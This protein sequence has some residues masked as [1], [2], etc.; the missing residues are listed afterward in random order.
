MTTPDI[1]LDYAATT[2]LDERVL[3]AMLPHLRQTH[4]NPNS[5]YHRGRIAHQALENAR[6]SVAAL[7]GAAYPSGVT[8][9][10]CGTES[11]N[12]A[13]IGIA[14]AVRRQS[15]R[16]HVVISAFEHHAVLEP[17]EALVKRGFELVTVGPRPD[18]VVHAEDLERVVT[19]RTALVSIMHVNNEIG[20]IMPLAALVEVA[21]TRGALFHSDTIQSVGKID[22]NVARLGLD[23]ASLSAHKIYGPKGVGAL[24]LKRG[25]PFVPY[26]MG[27]GQEFKHRS[28]TQNVAGAAGL[29]AALEIIERERPEESVRLATLRDRMVDAI[30]TGIPDTDLHGS[31]EALVPHIANLSLVG[32]EGESMLLQLDQKGIAVATGSAC[33]SGSLQPSHV[34]LAIGVDPDSAHASLRLSVGRYTTDEDVERFIAELPPIVERL[35][36]LSPA[37][38]RSQGAAQRDGRR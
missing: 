11:D 6:E 15:G 26:L 24:Y 31:R 27:G 34:L 30:L 3:E 7:I 20:T 12:A 14:E 13:V 28:G 17:A 21:H 23:A 2:P 10:G 25:T 16:S 19:D 9:T 32:V 18:G 1:Y 33:S 29:A 5:L 4:G 35:R 38:Q 22:M 8:F 37:Y 36:S